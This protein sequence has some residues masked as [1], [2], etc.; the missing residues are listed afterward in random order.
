MGSLNQEP[1]DPDEEDRI[2]KMTWSEPKSIVVIVANLEVSY[3]EEYRRRVSTLK[4]VKWD[5]CKTD[6]Y[7]DEAAREDGDGDGDQDGDGDGEISLRQKQT[8]QSTKLRSLEEMN[9]KRDETSFT[10]RVI[11][12]RGQL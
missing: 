11:E 8:Y 4:S 10:M 3:M 5:E 2:N 6:E 12:H 9:K 1:L 7:Y